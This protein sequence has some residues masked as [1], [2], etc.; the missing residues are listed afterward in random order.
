[1]TSNDINW[2]AAIGVLRGA[3]LGLA[4]LNILIPLIGILFPSAAATDEHSLWSVIATMIAPVMAPLF[5]TVILFDYIMSRIRAADAEGE[6]SRL[7][8]TIGRID[9]AVIGIS[10][11]F[12]VPYFAFLLP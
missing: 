6:Q 4:L 12:W 7:Y 10:L 1:M 5:V 2:P 3:L 9:L 8:T 11:L